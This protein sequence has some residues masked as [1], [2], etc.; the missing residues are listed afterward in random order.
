MRISTENYVLTD[1][2]GPLQAISMISD[3]GFDAF[4]ASYYWLPDGSSLLSE[5]YLA[6]AD[7]MRNRADEYGIVCNQAHAPFAIKY[8]ESFDEKN[9]NYRDIVRAIRA[10]GVLGA[11]VVVLHAIRIPKGINDTV[12]NYNLKFFSTLAPYAKEAGVKLGIEN[13]FLRDEERRCIGGLLS[14]PEEVNAIIDALGDD[15]FC[16]CVDIGH[17]AITG[18]DPANFIRKVGKR[19]LALH[20]QDCDKI[21]DRHMLPFTAKLDFASVA[22]ALCDVGYTGDVT[23]EIFKYYKTF[24]NERLATALKDACSAANTIRESLKKTKVYV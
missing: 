2:Y 7:K 9:R 13:L 21:D 6:L 10:A 8:G 4:D 12:H 16:A 24:P 11:K 14:S 18:N 5:G 19:C 1:R 22:D 17:A 20:I 3:A 23:L 15:T